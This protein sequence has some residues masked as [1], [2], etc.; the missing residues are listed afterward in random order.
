MQTMKYFC[1]KCE[2][3]GDKPKIQF[4][5]TPDMDF[6]S[7]QACPRCYSKIIELDPKKMVYDKYYFIGAYI[8]RWK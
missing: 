4:I 1:S 2:W 5:E 3:E 8:L 6:S 7:Y